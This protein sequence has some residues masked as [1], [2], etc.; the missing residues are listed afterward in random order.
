MKKEINVLVGKNIRFYRE[1]RGYTREK[2]AELLS[3]SPK[4]LYDCEVGSVGISLSILKKVCEILGVSDDCLI[5][6]KESEKLD[7]SERLK[8]IPS[9]HI[10]LIEKLIQ[11]QLEIIAIAT[12]EPQK[13]KKLIKKTKIAA[14]IFLKR[15]NF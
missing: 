8:H 1:N 6:D 9:E 13:N 7:I 3:V 2:L 15:S 10:E 12:K 14:F 5:W 11:N 4:F